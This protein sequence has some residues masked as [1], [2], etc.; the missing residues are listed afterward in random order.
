MCVRKE[1]R[2]CQD[3]GISLQTL[4]GLIFSATLST[5]YE[6]A[7]GLMLKKIFMIRTIKPVNRFIF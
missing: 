4:Y 1:D 7:D 3:W 6:K 2:N 5:N